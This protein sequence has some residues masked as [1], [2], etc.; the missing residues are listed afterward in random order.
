[1]VSHWEH[2]DQVLYHLSKSVFFVFFLRKNEKKECILFNKRHL[3]IKSFYQNVYVQMNCTQITANSY[4]IIIVWLVNTIAL[5]NQIIKG[6][7]FLTHNNSISPIK[8]IKKNKQQQQQQTLPVAKHSF[9]DQSNTRMMY[10]IVLCVFFMI[11]M[12]YN[13]IKNY[14]IK[15]NENVFV[16]KECSRHG[17]TNPLHSTKDLNAFVFDANENREEKNQLDVC[18]EPSAINHQ[19][20]QIK[21]YSNMQNNGPSHLNS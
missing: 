1:M 3:I 11:E 9:N 12:K 6:C 19:S 7:V 17:I 10:F 13:N 16:R 20:I 2:A 14:Q 18:I 4:W 5:Q 15:I 21:E 8:K